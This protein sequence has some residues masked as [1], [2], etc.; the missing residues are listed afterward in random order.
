[1]RFNLE[2]ETYQPVFDTASE[3][4]RGNVMSNGIGNT[5]FSTSG[6][7]GYSGTVYFTEFNVEVDPSMTK[8]E[9]EPPDSDLDINGNPYKP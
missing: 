3:R 5:L 6:V 2:M 8:N 9:Q 4:F 1:M 7:S